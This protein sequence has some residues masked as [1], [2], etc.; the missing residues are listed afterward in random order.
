MSAARL[1]IYQK[2]LSRLLNETP[3]VAAPPEEP[4]DPRQ[5]RLQVL[6]A[7]LERLRR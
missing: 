2:L 1:A 4:R 5:Q 3:P 6:Q 7:L